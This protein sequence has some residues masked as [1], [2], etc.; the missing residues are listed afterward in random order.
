MKI[1]RRRESV[2]DTEIRT[3]DRPDKLW[4]TLGAAI[5]AALTAALDL[6]IGEAIAITEFGDIVGRAVRT[7]EGAVLYL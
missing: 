6:P 7:E 4:P 1:P 2:P 3:S 5:A